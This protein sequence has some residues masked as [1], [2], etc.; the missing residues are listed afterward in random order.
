MPAEDEQGRVYVTDTGNKRVVVFDADG[1]FIT[2]FGSA[3]LD[4]GQFDEPVG[5]TVDKNGTVYVVNTWNES[6]ASP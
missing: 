6:G 4:A 5:I 3:G 2:E 1:N